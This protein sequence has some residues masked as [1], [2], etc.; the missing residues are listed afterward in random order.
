MSRCEVWPVVTMQRTWSS[1]VSLS[2][3]ESP[4]TSSWRRT[5]LGMLNSVPPNALRMEE[6]PRVPSTSTKSRIS[7]SPPHPLHSTTT[8][9]VAV[10]ARLPRRMISS[11][12]NLCR[13]TSE[14]PQGR[15]TSSDAEIAPRHTWQC[16]ASAWGGAG[17]GAES[18]GGVVDLAAE[19]GCAGG[20]SGGRGIKAETAV[21]SSPAGALPGA[22]G[23]CGGNDD[24]EERLERST[25]KKER[26]PHREEPTPNKHTTPRGPH[27]EDTKT[28]ALRKIGEKNME[29]LKFFATHVERTP[30]PLRCRAPF[31]FVNRRQSRWD[32]RANADFIPH[33]KSKYSPRDQGSM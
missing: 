23:I 1:K 21:W 22:S 5:R 13:A 19:V 3:Q 4:P 2:Y 30:S 9:A 18:P 27:S 14:C 17:A 8:A 7:T 25:E 24:E 20:T 32:T 11:A 33:L 6:S 10:D 31:P 26:H 28:N 29:K 16:K 12:H 15:R